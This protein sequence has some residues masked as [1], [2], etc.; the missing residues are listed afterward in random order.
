M[1]FT[2]LEKPTLKVSPEPIGSPYPLVT[3]PKLTLVPPEVNFIT[4]EA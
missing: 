4:S 3:K 1:V 2:D